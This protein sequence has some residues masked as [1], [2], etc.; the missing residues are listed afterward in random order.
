M[1]SV[2]GRGERMVELLKSDLTRSVASASQ[3]SLQ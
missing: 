1:D 2:C 3:N